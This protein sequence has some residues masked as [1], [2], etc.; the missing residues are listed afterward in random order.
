M[1]DDCRD[2]RRRSMADV[3]HRRADHRANFR[4]TISMRPSGARSVRFC[5]RHPQRRAVDPKGAGRRML[6]KRT[7]VH[8]RRCRSRDVANRRLRNE[9][10]DRR[11]GGPVVE[12]YGGDRGLGRRYP[13]STHST[14]SVG[15]SGSATCGKQAAIYTACLSPGRNE[16]L[17]DDT[18][19]GAA[20]RQ[21]VGVAMTEAMRHEWYTLGMH[22]G[23]RYE[24][25]PICIPDG[26]PPT[27]D[28]SRNYIPTARPG[29]RAPH[30]W[31]CRRP[32]DT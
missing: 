29:S 28:D 17:L 1:G 5:I 12:A 2:Q 23:Y 18:E 25:S 30:V 13:Y 4:P 19:I 10:G 32:L 20:L 7:S 3:D 24:N 27:P 16:E 31:L 22:L 21:R 6:S 9:H 14:P 11:C 8:I 26:T 15:R